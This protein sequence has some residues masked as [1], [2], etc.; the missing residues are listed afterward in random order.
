MNNRIRFFFNGKKYFTTTWVNLN[1]LLIY[2]NYSSSIFVVEYNHFI[3]D[4]RNWK[5]ITI[6]ENDR[7]EIITIVGGG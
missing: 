5:K 2:F 1:D 3:C 4:K 6:Q 7:I